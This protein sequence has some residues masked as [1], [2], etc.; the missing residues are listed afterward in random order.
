MKP[1]R[2]VRFA[3]GVGSALVLTMLLLPRARA[4]TIFVLT[5]GERVLFCNNEDWS[6][7]KTRI[8]FIPGGTNFNG[9]VYVGFDN[10]W[11]QGG[12]NTHGLAF[13]WV[14]GFKERWDPDPDLKRV[15]GNPSQRM[16]ETCTTVEEAAA[17]YRRYREPSF[18]YAKILVADRTGASAIIGARDGRLQVERSR[19]SHG[20]GF[21][22]RTLEDR[23][24]QTPAPTVANARSILTAC[25]Q[26]GPYATKYSN[27]FDLKSGDL[28]LYPVTGGDGGVGLNLA[29]ELRKGAHY[30]DLPEIRR[31]Q[32]QASRP[33]L[34]NM[35][36]FPID[37]LKPVPDREPQVTQRL[38]TILEEAAGGILRP[39]DFTEALWVRLAPARAAITADLKAMGALRSLTLVG[40][41]DEPGGRVYR[42]RVEFEKATVIERYLLSPDDRLADIQKEAEEP[43]P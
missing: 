5:D 15:R 3:R 40:R 13:D 19:R 31:Q 28:I 29:E 22:S 42:Y 2:E 6:N 30:Y 4:C 27:V 25:R 32:T 43:K 34:V 21:G 18:S 20:F 24:A 38:R 14:A 35:Q 1:K 17:F 26:T 36:R 33:L 23:L 8:W 11:A 16:L 37:A 10:G 7:P 12:L 9:C 39:E 41:E